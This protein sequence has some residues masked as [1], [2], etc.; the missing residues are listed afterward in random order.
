MGAGQSLL[1]KSNKNVFESELNKLD[2]LISRIITSDDKFIDPNYNFLFEE[3]CSKYTILWEKELNNHLK[4]DLQNL[5]GSLYLIPKKDIVNTNE[6]EGD[7]SKQELCKK[8]SKHYVK[9]LY[10][11]TLVKTVY[12]L[13]HSGDNSIAGIIQRNVRNVNNIME[14]H[15]CSI[16][17][18]DYDLKPADK[19]NF[20][21]LEG[22]KVF[23]EHFLT[24]VER[25]AFLEQFKAVFARKPRHKVLDAI[26]QDTLVP[27]DVYEKI[28]EKRFTEK[29][30]HCKK[31]TSVS[32]KSVDHLNLMFEVVADNPVLHTHYCYSHKKLIIPLDSNEPHV[33]KVNELY[34]EMHKHY[35]TNVDN[36]LAI[37]L[38]LVDRV[39]HDKYKLKNISNDQL[40]DIIKDVKKNVVTFYIQSIIDYQVLLDEAKLVPNLDVEA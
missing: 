16:P 18:K 31:D 6:K 23:V 2:E 4:V 1:N 22:F 35:V 21:H 26:C 8:I 34:K 17:H 28:Y 40:L 13:E 20:E 25:Y 9:I 15:Y 12:D 30:L 7:I 32:K 11:F 36:I 10:I 29:K 14:L 19:I 27:L 39:S 24:P 38:R 37:L 5:S 33:Q 3:V